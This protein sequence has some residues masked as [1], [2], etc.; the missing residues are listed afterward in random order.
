[1]AAQPTVAVVSDAIIGP[2]GV[3]WPR[4]DER[5]AGT[6]GEGSYWWNT[7]VATYAVAGNT[8]GAPQIH[9]D[10][11]WIQYVLDQYTFGGT[12]RILK[13]TSNN[14]PNGAGGPPNTNPSSYFNKTAD[15][16]EFVTISNNGVTINFDRGA[17]FLW[18][19]VTTSARMFL[20]TGNHCKIT[21]GQFARTLTGDAE[22]NQ[23]FFTASSTADYT[24]FEEE[25]FT[26]QVTGHLLNF[27]CINLAG[28]GDQQLA[29]RSPVIRNCHMNCGS[30]QPA[31]AYSTTYSAGA[32][33]SNWY[34]GI[35]LKANDCWQMEVIGCT[36]FADASATTTHFGGGFARLDNCQHAHISGGGIF[37]VSAGGAD[38]LTNG[39][40]ILIYT[41][42]GEAHHTTISD[43]WFEQCD[44]RYLIDLPAVLYDNIHD[45]SFGRIGCEACIHTKHATTS[46]TFPGVHLY[47]NGNTFHNINPSVA[48]ATSNGYTVHLEDIYGVYQGPI[49]NSLLNAGDNGLRVESTAKIVMHEG[50][51][52]VYVA[53]GAENGVAL[54]GIP[55]SFADGAGFV[56]RRTRYTN[57]DEKSYWRAR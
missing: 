47:L 22:T 41:A 32:T 42:G 19:D 14:D 48:L 57:R 12:F 5:D 54:A 23:T 4:G 2:D 40:G 25:Y 27:A 34:Q 35:L 50:K 20:I 15:D 29:M 55:Q 21:G 56:S 7:G 37:G 38:T 1:M 6:S 39:T 3:V 26:I 33:A 31:V 49:L 43:M 24:V 28:G 30:Q 36:V 44:F 18:T 51:H 13:G 46:S 16:D 52:S 11:A 17:A 8:G 53:D 10:T 9:S 45:V